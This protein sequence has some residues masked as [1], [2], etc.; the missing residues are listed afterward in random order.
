[1][2]KLARDLFLNHI[3][4]MV[5]G[6][7]L[8]EI[9]LFC[10]KMDDGTIKGLLGVLVLFGSFASIPLYI[11]SAMSISTSHYKAGITQP[12]KVRLLVSIIIAM[13]SLPMVWGFDFMPYVVYKLSNY[14]IMPFWAM[15]E[16][17]Y[18]IG[19]YYPML[20]KILIFL[21]SI[22]ILIAGANTQQINREEEFK[23][24]KEKY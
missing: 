17:F 20:N 4:F 24:E 7:I 1:M 12:F 23:S 22:L 11:L 15:T 21:P 2:K 8:Y 16:F 3:V 5:T 19:K 9:I 14:I 10:A 13:L 6:F 18:T